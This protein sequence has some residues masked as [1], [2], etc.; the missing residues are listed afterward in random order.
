[1]T[2]GVAWLRVELGN[3]VRFHY[4]VTTTIR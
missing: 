3:L 4:H 2:F 1:M